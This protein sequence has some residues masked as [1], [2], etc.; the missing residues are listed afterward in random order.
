MS[1][2]CQ[3]GPKALGCIDVEVTDEQRRLATSLT[4]DLVSL[5][6]LGETK[7][8]SGRGSQALH[9]WIDVLLT[10]RYRGEEARLSLASVRSVVSGGGG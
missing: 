8:S 5:G 6:R 1:A 10:C 9:Q 4:A 2:K 3:R 7:G